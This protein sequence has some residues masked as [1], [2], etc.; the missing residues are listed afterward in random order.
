MK[1]VLSVCLGLFVSATAW[2]SSTYRCSDPIGL[3]DSAIE[4]DIPID[5]TFSIIAVRYMAWHRTYEVKISKLDGSFNKIIKL[6][7]RINHMYFVSLDFTLDAFG[8]VEAD[9]LVGYLSV[10]LNNL[11]LAEDFVIQ[12]RL[13]SVHNDGTLKQ[14]PS[15]PYDLKCTSL[16]RL[17]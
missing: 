2:A 1:Y 13:D 17:N 15:A 3:D 16:E 9:R 6:D 11:N 4:L 14:A 5:E 10:D 7:G 8:I 12:V